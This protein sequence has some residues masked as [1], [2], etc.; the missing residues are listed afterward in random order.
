MEFAKA[1]GSVMLDALP[2][3]AS[4]CWMHYPTCIVKLDALPHL[5]GHAGCTIGFSHAGCTTPLCIVSSSMFQ[6]QHHAP[7]RLMQALVLV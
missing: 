2:H 7:A 1:S 5:N 4:S 3:F 6:L